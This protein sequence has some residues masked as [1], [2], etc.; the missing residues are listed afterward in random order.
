[1]TDFAEDQVHLV[2]KTSSLR[3]ENDVFHVDDY[4]ENTAYIQLSDPQLP[5][6]EYNVPQKLL[7]S[8]KPATVG[9]GKAWERSYEIFRERRMDVC[10]LDLEPFEGL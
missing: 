1:M 8:A 5:G 2:A 7:L 3:L 10:G 9:P 6:P 4:L